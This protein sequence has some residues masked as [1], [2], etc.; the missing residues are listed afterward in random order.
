MLWPA[1]GRRITQ[2]FK[3]RHQAI[4]I[5]G[6]NGIDPIYA[7]E[8]GVVESAGWGRGGWGNTIIVNHG[9]GM[10]TRYSHANKIFVSPGETVQKGQ[11]IALIGS[12]GRS[13]GP[14]VDFRVYIT[15]RTVNPLQYMR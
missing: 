15:G 12:T 1:V 3:W 11:T 5:G 6:K 14:H 9:N 2:Y 13:T 8:N 10:K 4:D 7:A